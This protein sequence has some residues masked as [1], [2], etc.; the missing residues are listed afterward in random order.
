MVDLSHVSRKAQ[1]MLVLRGQSAESASDKTTQILMQNKGSKLCL[2]SVF[3]SLLAP[4]LRFPHVWTTILSAALPVLALAQ[5]SQLPQVATLS[6]VPLLVARPARFATKSQPSAA[7]A[8]TP[9]FGARFQFDR[10]SGFL[11]SGGFAF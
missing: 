4:L 5:L 11:L 2:N 10:R 3:F 9:F 1:K 7:K 6:R 8:N